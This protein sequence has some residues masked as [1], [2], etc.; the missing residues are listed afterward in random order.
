MEH[1]KLYKTEKGRIWELDFIRGFCIFLMIMDHTFYD[2]AFVFNKQWFPEPEPGVF[3]YRLCDFAA[4]YFQWIGRELVWPIAVLCF[5]FIS[6]ISCSFSLSNARRGFRFAI[7]AIALTAFTR[8]M[9]W[10]AGQTDEFTI[11]FGILH[12]LASSILIYCIVRK[13]GKI[14]MLFIG[15]SSIAAGIY[16]LYIPLETSIYYMSVLV[17]STSDFYS[18]DYFPLLP[19][20]GFFLIGATIG[21][22]L[23]PDRRSL[24]NADVTSRWMRPVLFTGRHSLIFYILHQPAVYIILTFIGLFIS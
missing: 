9:D 18:A 24:F 21:P 15:L 5:I 13:L 19:W 20:F 11:R 8:G 10:Y 16:F 7:V 2:L 22:S 1:S 14:P 3:L 23:Y 12:M 17:N 6:G 4:I